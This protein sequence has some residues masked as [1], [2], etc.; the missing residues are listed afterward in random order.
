MTTK[1]KGGA[2]VSALE[3]LHETVAEVMILQLEASRKI[4]EEEGIDILATGAMSN[5]INFLKHNNISASP[6]DDTLSRLNSEFTNN[7]EFIAARAARAESITKS[8]GDD[9]ILFT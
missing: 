7:Q 6:D 8:A 9:D 2:K 5:I 4:Y 3:R 1:K